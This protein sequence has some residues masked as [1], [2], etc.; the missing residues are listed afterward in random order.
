MLEVA[1]FHCATT[2]CPPPSMLDQL[3]EVEPCPLLHRYRPLFGSC[4]RPL[5]SQDV[6]SGV[7]HVVED[8]TAH[9]LGDL[10][11]HNFVVGSVSKEGSHIAQNVWEGDC[12][13]DNVRQSS[14]LA[15]GLLIQSPQQF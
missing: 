12:I 3:I 4:A 10:V 7:L 15:Q 2:F 14:F 5:N 9:F 8:S 6:N 1:L 11:V 13:W